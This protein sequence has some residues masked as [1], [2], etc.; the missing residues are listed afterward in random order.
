MYIVKVADKNPKLYI[1]LNLHVD[2]NNFNYFFLQ[3]FTLFIRCY[4]FK[5]K[6]IILEFMS[7]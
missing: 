6:K 3:Y 7:I 1:F 5:P 4:E 2:F